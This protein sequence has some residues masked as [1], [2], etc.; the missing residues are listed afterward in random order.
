MVASSAARK[1]QAVQPKIRYETLPREELKW[2]AVSLADVIDTGKR[3]EASVFDVRGKHAREAIENCKWVSTPL[4]G[5]KGIAMAY[6][7]GRFKHVWLESSDLPIY[8][9]SSITDIKP[10]PDGF[11][12]KNTKTDV[13]ALR[14]HTGQVLLTCSGTIGKV[15]LVSNTLDG[16]IFSHDLIRL[17]ANDPGDAGFIYTFLCSD[18]GNTILQTNNYG[19]VIQHIEAEHLADIPIPNPAPEIKAKIN[20][21]IL[22]SFALR[23]ESNELVDKATSL[24]TDALNLPP[25]HDFFSQKFDYSID[26][27]NYTVKLSEL[28]GRLDG[29]YHVPII[30]AITEHLRKHASEVTTVGDKKV[31]RKILLPGRFKRVYVEEGQGRVFI[32]GKQI[33]ELDP[34][35]KK[36]L[37]LVHHAT[38]IQDQ[39]ELK[40]NMTLITC[41]GTIGKVALV[42]RHWDGWAASQHIIRI[43]PAEKNVAGYISMFLGSDYGYPLITRFSY[44]SVVD[45]IDDYHVSQIPFPFLKDKTTQ[46]EINNL[47]LEANELRYQAYKLEQEAMKIMNNEVIFA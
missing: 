3:L 24:L 47:A 38:R 7:C 26:A 13:E 28:A 33:F 19:A 35:N 37:S 29:S 16:K 15:T 42:P 8:Q 21:H 14:V 34:S 41:S 32:G 18:I 2:C 23:D 43:I 11:L 10:T 9:P 30:G 17:S 40:E 31:S 44:G 25:I 36:Y 5:E 46:D 6:T 27:N 45:E 39:L 12:S 1:P 22:R 20:N 4:C